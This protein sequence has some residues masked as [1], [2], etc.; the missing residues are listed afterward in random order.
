MLS[1]EIPGVE[2]EPLFPHPPLLLWGNGKYRVILSFLKD[3]E[4]KVHPDRA[5][6]EVCQKD[7]LGGESWQKTSMAELPNSFFCC[8]YNVLNI[9]KVVGEENG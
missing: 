7:S 9:C 2:E 3:V 4:G 6:L 5:V 8:M 1:E